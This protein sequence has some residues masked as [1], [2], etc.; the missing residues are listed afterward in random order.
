MIMDALHCRLALVEYVPL[1]CS[2]GQLVTP[3]FV[4]VMSRDSAFPCNTYW[5]T[6]AYR[7]LKVGCCIAAVLYWLCLYS[8]TPKWVLLYQIRQESNHTTNN[9]LGCVHLL[10][11]ARGTSGS[12]P[13]GIS[14]MPAH[15]Y[16]FAFAVSSSMCLVAACSHANLKL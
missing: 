9:G 12:N 7:F 2:N 11:G 3:E 13:L 6:Y 10:R 8:C 4:C 15:C 14:T 5:P 1:V 16:C